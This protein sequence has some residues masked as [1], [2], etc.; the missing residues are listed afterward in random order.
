MSNPKQPT[1]RPQSAPASAAAN[2]ARPDD[3]ALRQ[4]LSGSRESARQAGEQLIQENAALR[5]GVEEARRIQNELRREMIALAEPANLLG[6]ITSVERNGQLRATVH[7][8][9]LPAVRAN[10]HPTIDPDEITVGVPVYLSQDRACVLGL[11]D[12]CPWKHIGVF[13]EHIAGTERAIV[14]FQ[15]QL[16]PV[17]LVIEMAE[18]SLAR[19][20][21]VGFNLDAGVAFIRL[22]DPATKYLFAEDLPMDDFSQLGGLEPQIRQIKRLV[23]FAIKYP[24]TATRF[25]VPRKR[26]ILLLGP[27][28]NGKTRLARCTANYIRQLLPD[29]PC[30]FQSICGSEDY[31]MWLGG[32]EQRLKERFAAARRAAE[33]GPVVL[34]FDE[35][36]AVAKLRGTDHGSG[37]PDRI[38]ATFLGLLDDVQKTLGNVLIMGATNRAS[39]LDPGLTR[40]GRLDY[41]L[42]IPPPNRR[43]AEL[44]LRRYLETCPLAEPLDELLAPAV[45]RIFS[46]RGP[47][48]ELVTVRLSD[49]RRLVIHGREL[50]SGAMLENI[51]RRAA[52]AAAV[53]QVETGDEQVVMADDL[54]LSLDEELTSTAGLLGPANVKSYIASIPQDAHPVE[55]RTV[56]TV[57]ST[58]LRNNL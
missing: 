4:M 3:D 6:T 14:R 10:V 5:V 44:I 53:R 49:G 51:V 52:E 47:Y 9:G 33:S 1:S 19:G 35:I 39:L 57:G 23:D 24:E 11:S 26:G 20:D 8:D 54:T 56:P 16:V 32:T 41:K 38:L 50:L 21:R 27:P 29:M 22:P 17:K 30:R 13:E 40:P 2:G 45:H 28:G 18:V 55:V 46:P 43:A 58:Y 34:F 48:A 7:V 31:S 12:H 25:G 36:D 15:E 37:A 42:T